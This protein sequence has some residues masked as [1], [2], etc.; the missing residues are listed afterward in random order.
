MT[1][2][3]GT[4]NS[5]QGDILLW[6]MDHLSR[7]N[8]RQ[9]PL[10]LL[11]GRLLVL[12]CLLLSRGSVPVSR[13]LSVALAWVQPERPSHPPSL[14]LALLLFPL[15]SPFAPPPHP[16][17]AGRRLQ[18]PGDAAALVAGIQGR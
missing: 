5:L 3:L 18:Q 4:E 14:A 13:Q 17:A 6:Q 8:P 2:D 11:S 10:P 1:S 12:P 7:E 15:C 9:H 16:S